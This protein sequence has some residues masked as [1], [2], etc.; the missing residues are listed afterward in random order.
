MS[1]AEFDR[2]AQTYETMHR[3]SIGFSGTSPEYFARYK[4]AHAASVAAGSKA[5]LDFGSGIGNSIP[6]FKTFFPQAT[7]T[8]ADVSKESLEYSSDKYPESAT[9]LQIEGETLDIPGN[10]V[11]LAFT[12]CVFHHIPPA[13]HVSWLAELRRVTRPAGQFL[14]FEHNPL[15]PLTRK[16]VRDC[17]FDADAILIG[18]REMASRMQAAGWRIIRIDHHVFFPEFL[19]FMRISE[20]ALHW[21]PLG[22]QYSILAT[23]EKP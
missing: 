11:D 6:H 15:N 16:A 10:A 8:C 21:L 18:H 9:Y 12:A 5:L 22:G 17:E 13:Q 19:R 7:L 3:K 1:N 14:L 20:H 23:K 4:I 2:F